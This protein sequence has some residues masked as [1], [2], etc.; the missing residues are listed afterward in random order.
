MGNNDGL[1]NAFV[2]QGTNTI[3]KFKGGF[4]SFAFGSEIALVLDDWGGYY[5]LN[6]DSSLFD[7][8]KTKVNLGLSKKELISFWLEKSKTFEV[9]KWSNSFCIL[10]VAKE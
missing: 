4:F 8:V 7:E 3:I 6:C 2:S 1:V 9:S 10:E 5:I